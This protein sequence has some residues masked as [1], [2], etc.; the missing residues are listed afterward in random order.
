VTDRQT[1]GAFLRF[2]DKK[3][4]KYTTRPTNY[5]TYC[6]KHAHKNTNTIQPTTP[7]RRL[8]QS[9]ESTTEQQ[10]L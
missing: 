3:A 7:F 6:L 4:Q 2:A 1:Y 10:S 9:G 5:T 8:N